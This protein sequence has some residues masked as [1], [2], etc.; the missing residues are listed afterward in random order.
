MNATIFLIIYVLFWLFSLLIYIQVFKKFETTLIGYLMILYGVS[1]IFSIWVVNQPLYYASPLYRFDIISVLPL[2]YLWACVLLFASPIFFFRVDKIQRILLTSVYNEKVVKNNII[3]LITIIFICA[4]LISFYAMM[5]NL[6]NFSSVTDVDV[7]TLNKQELQLENASHLFT[8]PIISK[9][10]NLYKML[11][12]SM[13][14]F[15]FYYGI[16][17][18]KKLAVLLFILSGFFPIIFGIANGSR[19]AIILSLMSI[20]ITY[21]IFKN[22]LTTSRRNQ[23]FK[24]SLVL[25]IIMSIPL[26]FLSI[27]RFGD[28]SQNLVYEIVRYFGEPAVNFSSELFEHQK[29][30]LYGYNSFPYFMDISIV[31]R[32]ILTQQIAGILGYVFYTFI[33]NLVIDFGKFS[34]F[35]FGIGILFISLKTKLFRVN[36]GKVSIGKIILIQTICLL[37]F[38]G[39]FCF[40]YILN[41]MALIFG[42]FIFMFLDTNWITFFSEFFKK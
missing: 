9:F 25:V 14:C 38:Q 18:R 39:I 35:L 6:K 2:L 34:V 24:L 28:Y 4:S 5:P 10:Y 12:D 19:G 20:F 15:A 32:R 16:G 13:L 26:L 30:L 11:C 42:I 33:G 41:P 40:S 27:L 22:L 8:N 29:G 31:D 23:I 36:S 21:Q 37:C 17:G 1:G 3:F 7:G